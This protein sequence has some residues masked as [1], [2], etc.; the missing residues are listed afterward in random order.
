MKH[1]I[2][3]SLILFVVGCTK[4]VDAPAG[5]EE[6]A[7]TPTVTVEVLRSVK[8]ADACKQIGG[9]WWKWSSQR[10][11]KQTTGMTCSVKTADSGKACSSSSDCEGNYCQAGPRAKAGEKATGKCVGW[12]GTDPAQPTC[13]Q[14][15]EGGIAKN[16]SC[17]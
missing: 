11:P 9:L 17:D 5:S 10:I 14:R 15:V 7:K 2:F 16:M 1:F 3:C 12:I 4:N 8:D 13:W 6:S